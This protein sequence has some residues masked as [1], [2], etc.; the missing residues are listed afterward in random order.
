MLSKALLFNRLKSVMTK[1]KRQYF[2]KYEEV[3]FLLDGSRKSRFKWF[4]W[5]VN[6]CYDGRGGWGQAHTD[7]R[8]E[9]DS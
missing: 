2:S 6:L 4:F 7:V 8:G 1:E 9:G 3:A 5:P